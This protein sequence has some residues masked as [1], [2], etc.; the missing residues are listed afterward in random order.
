MD[1][2]QQALQTIRKLFSYLNFVYKLAIGQKPKNIQSRSSIFY[3]Y[4]NEF[5]STSSSN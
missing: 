2:S 5:D 1:S 4:I 3:N